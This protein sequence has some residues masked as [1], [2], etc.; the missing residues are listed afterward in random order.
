MPEIQPIEETTLGAAFRLS[1][2]N[3]SGHSSTLVTDGLSAAVSMPSNTDYLIPTDEQPLYPSTSRNNLASDGYE[4]KEENV[5]STSS[6]VKVISDLPERDF[7]LDEVADALSSIQG[8]HSNIEDKQV[9]SLLKKHIERPGSFILWY[10]RNKRRPAICVTHDGE[11]KTLIVHKRPMTSD[12]SKVDFYFI[13]KDEKTTKNL[14]ELVDHHLTSGVHPI[15]MDYKE[16]SQRIRETFTRH[17]IP[18]NVLH[19]FNKYDRLVLTQ[20]DIEKVKAWCNNHGNIEAANELLNRLIIYKDWFRCLLK[21]L[22]D[23]D[24]K[25]G[26]VAD[27]FQQIFERLKEESNQELE[28]DVAEMVAQEES[29][30]TKHIKKEPKAP[31]NNDSLLPWNPSVKET[32][33]GA[34][35]ASE[36]NILFLALYLHELSGNGLLMVETEV[37]TSRPAPARYKFFG[38]LQLQL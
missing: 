30:V 6:R 16:L 8:W 38:N 34:Q 35:S 19:V 3:P 7:T 37:T 32:T 2:I 25:L 36:V 24:V 28:A 11:I 33:G 12:P 4:N 31:M 17:V 23:E 13:N 21:V 1:A 29:K 27:E 10:W 14:K 15:I 9:L 20:N 22:R 26:H 18:G 5:P